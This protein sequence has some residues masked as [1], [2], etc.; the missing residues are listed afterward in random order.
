MRGILAFLV[1][2]TVLA[3]ACTVL[4]PPTPSPAPP[5]PTTP[6]PGTPPPTEMVEPLGDVLVLRAYSGEFFSHK[7][8]TQLGF[9]DVVVF[10]DGRVVAVSTSEIGAG[11]PLYASLM[12]TS[13]ELTQ[14]SEQL[15][16]AALDGIAVGAF[17]ERT[18]CFDCGTTIIR[19]DIDGETIEVSAHGLDTRASPDYVANL[20]Y[21]ETLIELDRTLHEFRQRV[22]AEGQPFDGD[23]PQIPVSPASGG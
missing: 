16:A 20:P 5:K 3:S 4:L 10:D 17:S 11:R 1:A 19:T 18:H 13:E 21:P 6:R 12:L 23:I 22:A 14:L 9:P 2:A 7:E 8:R 15:A